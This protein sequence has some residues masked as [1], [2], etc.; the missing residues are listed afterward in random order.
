MARADDEVRARLKAGNDA[1]AARF[2]FIFIRC[3]SGLEAAE[4]LASLERRLA[5]D[6]DTE[7][8]NAAREQARITRLRLERW[9]LAQGAGPD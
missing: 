8:R 4:V 7:L 9:L 3:A 2:G 1:Y 5:N 6:R